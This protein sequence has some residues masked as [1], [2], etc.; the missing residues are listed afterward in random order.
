M[1]AKPS[2]LTPRNLTENLKLLID[3]L[4][5]YKFVVCFWWPVDVELFGVQEE[6]CTFN[7]WR[8]VVGCAKNC[9]RPSFG[10]LLNLYENSAQLKDKNRCNSRKK[11]RSSKVQIFWLPCDYAHICIVQRN[12]V[13]TT[14]FYFKIVTRCANLVHLL[15]LCKMCC[16]PTSGHF[17]LG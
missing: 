12:I 8:A 10:S 6:H 11:E 5:F 9:Q 16:R 13:F 2:Q 14:L 15:M 1:K 4:F 17:V 3:Q 7:R